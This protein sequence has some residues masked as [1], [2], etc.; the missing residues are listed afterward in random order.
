MPTLESSSR[1]Q[2]PAPAQAWRE[3]RL[4]PASEAAGAT[5]FNWQ[6]PSATGPC[7]AG[8]G[9]WASSEHT[10]RVALGVGHRSGAEHLPGSHTRWPFQGGWEETPTGSP[11]AGVLGRTQVLAEGVK[12]FQVGVERRDGHRTRHTR[13]PGLA[14]C[15]GP[16]NVGHQLSACTG[17]CPRI[18]FH[19][20]AE[21]SPY[22]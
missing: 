3:P 16:A 11:P 4:L 12:L 21:R 6:S 14:A 8:G 20:Q 10:A 2:L 18:L 1:A 5:P 15:T 22:K 19:G 7:G 17:R 13:C 9:C